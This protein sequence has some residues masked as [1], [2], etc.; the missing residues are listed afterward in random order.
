M[1]PLYYLDNYYTISEFFRTAYSFFVTKL[2][3]PGARL[4]R[5]PVYL[6]GRPRMKWGDGFTTGF[7][8]RLEA[9][10][11]GREDTRLRLI[12]GRNCR[13]GDRV[14]I[15]A[16]EKVAIG[17]NCLIA[18]NVFI[19]DLSHGS[20]HGYSQVSPNIAPEDRKLVSAPVEIGDNVWIGEGVCILMGV[21]IGSGSVIGAHSVVTKDVPPETI[22]VGAP[23]R[24]VRRYYHDDSSWKHVGSGNA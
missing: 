18:S 12:V 7:G 23:A 5:R 1:A 11:S 10:G 16:L 17:D 2:F 9:F 3:Y 24:V 6:R 14:H 15:A 4:L 13:M 19:S 8:C 20:Y 22:V 21:R